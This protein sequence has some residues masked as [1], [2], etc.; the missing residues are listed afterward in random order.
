MLPKS[1]V[2]KQTP[3]DQYTRL[4]I[5]G[6]YGDALGAFE[7]KEMTVNDYYRLTYFLDCPDCWRNIDILDHDH[8]LSELIKEA[9]KKYEERKRECLRANDIC[10]LILYD[11]VLQAAEL[12]YRMAAMKVYFQL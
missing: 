12:F 6:L 4:L 8:Y 10:A 9:R 3:E 5:Y 11:L 2:G 1:I 7:K